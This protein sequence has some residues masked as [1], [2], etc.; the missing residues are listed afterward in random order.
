MYIH[1]YVQR[2]GSNISSPSLEQIQRTIKTNKY[3]LE[4][5]IPEDTKY[6][7]IIVSH[8]LSNCHPERPLAVV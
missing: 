2:N 3:R 5:Q 7:N 6:K 4:N 1:L 8:G